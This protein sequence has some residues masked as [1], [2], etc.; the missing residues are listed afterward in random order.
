[1]TFCQ[2]AISK[3]T[4]GKALLDKCAATFKTVVNLVRSSQS[5]TITIEYQLQV[6]GETVCKATLRKIYPTTAKFF[7][8]DFQ[9]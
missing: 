9:P 3:K 1:M 6:K 2:D 5:A 4:G 7:P 8:V